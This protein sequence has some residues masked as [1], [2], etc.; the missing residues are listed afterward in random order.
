MQFE[1][2]KAEDVEY[3][4]SE[5]VVFEEKGQEFIGEFIGFFEFEGAYGPGIGY[6]FVDVDDPELEYTIFG[7]SVLKTKM[8]NVPVNAIVKIVY[9]GKKK[10]EKTGRMY[11]E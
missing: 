11:K 9:E 5:R 1:E 3:K 2:M 8:K 10:S 4:E 7:D 6:K